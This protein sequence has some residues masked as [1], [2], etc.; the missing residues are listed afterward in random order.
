M[1]LKQIEKNNIVIWFDPDNF[2][3]SAIEEILTENIEITVFKLG[4][5]YIDL[6]FKIDSLLDKADPPKMIIYLPVKEEATNFALTEAIAAGVVMKPG[7]QPPERNTR[8]SVVIQRAL[9]GILSDKE[10]EKVSKQADEGLYTLRDLDAMSSKP[11]RCDMTL[12]KHI[13]GT[14]NHHEIALLFLSNKTKDS[15]IIEKDALKEIC[16][17]FNTIYG[18]DFPQSNQPDDLRESV[19]NLLLLT[20][21]FAQIDIKVPE[22]LSKIDMPEGRCREECLDLVRYWRNRRSLYPSYISQADRVQQLFSLE[23]MKL[24]FEKIVN[25]ETF[26]FLEE[27]IQEELEAS[28]IKDLKPS[29]IE[30][31]EKRQTTFWPEN[32]PEIQARWALILIAGKLINQCSVLKE[33]IKNSTFSLSELMDRYTLAEKPW[34]IVDKL[35]RHMERLYQAIEVDVVESNKYDTLEKLIV[36]ARSEYVNIANSISETFI[37][38]LEKFPDE[39]GSVFQQRNIYRNIVAPLLDG[40]KTAYILVDALRFEI[41]LELA[42]Q[43]KEQFDVELKCSLASVPSITEVGMAALMPGAEDESFVY[44]PVKDKLVPKIQG[45]V[46]KD[47]S[48]RINLLKNKINN[49]YEKKLESLL[50]PS[51]EVRKKIEETDFLIITSQEIDQ[52][53][54]VDNMLVARKLMGEIIADL[55]R[56]IK[57]LQALGVQNFVVTADHGFIFGEELGSDMKIDPPGGRTI[58]LHRR[59]WAGYGGVNNDSYIRFKSS[60]FG[61]GGDYDLVFPIS[62]GCFKVAGGNTI[63][64]HGGLSPQEVIIP[65]LIIKTGEELKP[66]YSDIR[67]ELILGSKS[68][69]TRFISVQVIGEI[70]NMALEDTIYVRIELRDKDRVLSQTVSATY[71]FSEAS[72]DVELSIDKEN[73]EVKP[74]TITLMLVDYAEVSQVSLHLINSRT[75]KELACLKEIELKLSI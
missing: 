59:V 46:V 26:R 41:G 63:Y 28:M 9:E 67:W 58:S 13:F 49:L 50:P 34:C 27:V 1:V 54:E 2:Y 60:L 25:V 71:G 75:G 3:S 66:M 17:L 70:V 31:A 48:D 53:A 11:K 45:V 35:H 38:R 10:I 23:E 55:K 24:E 16:S 8:L 43:L 74:N 21:F 68:I 72:S 7:Q 42:E 29:L 57:T 40:G 52:L 18:L 12:L 19:F 15:D 69:S 4:D 20:D 64:F 73:R 32:I 5:S 22:A 6:R 65:V 39:Y 56:A 62:L 33:I 51:R 37:K 14:S 47:R 30:V 61:L 36:K 44:E